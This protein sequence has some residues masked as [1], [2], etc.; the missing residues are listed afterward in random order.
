MCY[1]FWLTTAAGWIHVPSMFL[2]LF[3][4][5]KLFLLSTDGQTSQNISKNPKEYHRCLK[6]LA[7]GHEVK[8]ESKQTLLGPC[9]AF[10]QCPRDLVDSWLLLMKAVSCF[11]PAQYFCPSSREPAL[12]LPLQKSPPPTLLLY[13]LHAVW[14]TLIDKLY[15]NT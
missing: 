8:Y 2:S 15:L 4:H 1:H 12:L 11:H 6:L 10:V 9:P 7:L 5:A 14:Y 3:L 13:I